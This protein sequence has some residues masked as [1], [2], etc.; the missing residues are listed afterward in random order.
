MLQFLFQFW[1]K[2]SLRVKS[3]KWW[4]PTH[5]ANFQDCF[6]AHVNIGNY[7]MNCYLH[8]HARARAHPLPHTHTHKR[9]KKKKQTKTCQNWEM[10][11]CKSQ[12]YSGMS[13]MEQSSRLWD[14]MLCTPLKV[15][16][17]FKG[18]CSLH[19]QGLMVTGSKQISKMLV[20]LYDVTFQLHYS[21]NVSKLIT[22]F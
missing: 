4:A 13:S 7:M 2:Y 9:R 17:H 15:S 22:L 10:W 8:M 12:R 21:F 3:S 11:Q 18:I 14:I 6:L 5:V 1:L 20:D 16:W 19:F